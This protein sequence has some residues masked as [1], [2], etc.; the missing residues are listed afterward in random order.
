MGQY[1][2][3][4]Y[5]S[6]VKS[7]EEADPFTPFHT[8]T[9]KG[10]W[11]IN[12]HLF[13]NRFPGRENPKYFQFHNEEGEWEEVRW[14]YY[15]VDGVSET[16]VYWINTLNGPGRKWHTFNI[17]SLKTINTPKSLNIHTLPENLNHF[18][19]LIICIKHDTD[20]TFVLVPGTTIL[21]GQ[22]ALVR[23]SSD[24]RWRMMCVGPVTLWLSTP[25]HT[26]LACPRHSYSYLFTP[27]VWSLLMLALLLYTPQTVTVTSLNT[28]HS[29]CDQ[30]QCWSYRDTSPRATSRLQTVCRSK[31][32]P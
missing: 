12:S 16:W 29:E 22:G 25:G 20:L 28:E 26:A 9:V 23:Q 19:H 2:V 8:D 21:W 30:N 32:K 11:A 15:E 27:R 13:V 10:I 14:D 3:I 1:L 4:S 18:N 17:Q 31:V 5:A 24:A 6:N 7:V